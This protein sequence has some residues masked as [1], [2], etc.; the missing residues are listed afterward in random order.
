MRIGV[1]ITLL[2][3]GSFVTSAFGL[4][5]K[6]TNKNEDVPSDLKEIVEFKNNASHGLNKPFL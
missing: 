4:G 6:L 5:E 1:V 3:L 2:F